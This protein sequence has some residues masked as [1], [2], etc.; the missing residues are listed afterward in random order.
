MKNSVDENQTSAS[1]SVEKARS[2]A[3][4]GQPTKLCKD[5]KWAKRDNLFGIFGGFRFAQCTAPRAQKQNG[6]ILV[7]GK[8]N[9][10]IGCLTHRGS[11]G[12]GIY[13]GT[14]ARFW[15]PKTRNGNRT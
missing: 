14:E 11:S 13:C 15:E 3:V 2:D 8:P 1:V 7:D 4:E 5:C 6:Q 9:N 10:V 12:F